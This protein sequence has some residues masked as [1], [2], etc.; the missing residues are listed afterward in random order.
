LEL[1]QDLIWDVIT[2]RSA[3]IEQFVRV[4]IVRDAFRRYTTGSC[5]T[6]DLYNLWTTALLAMWLAREIRP[7]DTPVMVDNICWQA[8]SRARF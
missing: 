1:N 6:Q 4:P 3:E 8:K 5:S 2:N 7:V